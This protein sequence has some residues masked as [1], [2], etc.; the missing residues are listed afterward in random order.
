[1]SLNAEVFTLK[2]SEQRI[3]IRDNGTDGLLGLDDRH[4]VSIAY[5]HIHVQRRVTCVQP[6]LPFGVF[7]VVVGGFE[8]VSDF[9]KHYL[10][11]LGLPNL[12]ILIYRRTEIGKPLRSWTGP[13]GMM[14]EEKLLTPNHGRDGAAWYDYI[15][16]HYNNPPIVAA[17]LHGHVAQA[18][19][20]SCHA[21]FTRITRYYLGLA[22]PTVY[23]NI[24]GMITLTSKPDGE[25]RDP[26][27]WYGGKRRLL[28]D[29]WGEQERALFKDLNITELD[30]GFNSCCGSF[31][32]RGN[33]FRQLDINVYLKLREY[34]SDENLSDQVTGRIG[35][36]FV[37][38]RLWN[39]PSRT[40]EHMSAWYREADALVNTDEFSLRMEAC[41]RSKI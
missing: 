12:Y 3:G 28:E 17:F 35:Y 25:D 26:F 13:C 27:D 15:V 10:W 19:H 41:I 39:D 11:D 14:A 36:E 32:T 2:P 18:W 22:Q 21:I 1:V 9:H 7:H 24:D 40:R 5:S 4:N 29:I 23:P 30:N 6:S 31:I 16:G 37:I 20:T 38:Y 34:V 33:N 8:Y